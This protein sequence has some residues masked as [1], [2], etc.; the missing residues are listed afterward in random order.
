METPYKRRKLEAVNL[1]PSDTDGSE[2]EHSDSVHATRVSEP[3]FAY[4]TQPTQILPTTLPQSSHEEQASQIQVLASSPPSIKQSQ[5]PQETLANTIAPAGTS[6]RP[7]KAYLNRTSSSKDVDIINITDD[8][9]AQRHEMSSDDENESNSA[10]IKPTLFSSRGAHGLERLKQIASDARYMSGSPSRSPQSNSNVNLA[11]LPVNEGRRKPQSAEQAFRSLPTKSLHDVVKVN[12]GLS[13]A[14]IGDAQMQHKIKKMMEVAPSNSVAQC[15]DALIK[16]GNNYQDA[17]DHLFSL[18]GL[19]GLVD[20]TGSDND[21]ANRQESRPNLSSRQNWPAKHSI[22]P[23]VQKIHEKYSTQSKTRN[24]PQE[25]SR[26]AALPE[27]RRRLVQGRKDS[28]AAFDLQDKDEDQPILKSQSPQAELSDSGFSETSDGSEADLE[29][30]V[31]DFLNTCD[32][33]NIMDTAGASEATASK[34]ISRRPFSNLDNIRSLPKDN[35]GPKSRGQRTDRACES[36]VDKTLDMWRGYQA[37]DALIKRCEELARPLVEAMASWG[38]NAEHASPRERAV[39]LSIPHRGHPLRDSGVGSPSSRSESPN[40]DGARDHGALVQSRNIG[41]HDQPSVM[42]KEIKLKDFQVIGFNWLALL[43]DHK[44]SAILADD[45]GLGKTCQIIAFLAHLFEK[46]ISGPHLVIVPGSTLENWLREFA[47]FCPSLA[48]EPYYGSQSERP[49]IRERISTNRKDLNVVITTYTIAKMKDD[50]KFL[51]KLKPT[52]CI[53]DEGHVLKNSKSAGYGAYMGIQTDFRVLLS[54]TPV[55]NSLSELC[56]LLGFILP[57]VFQEYT[58]DLEAIFS[59]KARTT[60]DQRSHSALLSMQRVSRAKSIMTPFVLRR[61]KDQ[62]LQELPKKTKRV[63]YCIMSESQKRLYQLEKE[64]ARRL[65]TDGQTSGLSKASQN[66]M[67]ALRKAAIHPLLFRSLYTNN[68]L[69]E[70]AKIC[71]KEPEFAKSDV[72]LVY[73]DMTVMDDIELHL[74]CMRYPSTLS[75]YQLSDNEW[76]DSGK[77]KVLEGL[78]KT[79]KL[80]GEKV[81]VFSQFVQVLNILEL[82]LETLQIAFFRLDGQTKIE[83]RQ[84]MIDQYHSDTEITVFLLSTKAGGA[85]INLACANKVIIVDSSFNPQDDIQAENRAHRVGQTSEVEVVRLVS[86]STIEE[87]IHTLGLTKLL[88]DDR[89]A[90]APGENNN[91]LE[92]QGKTAL[93]DIVRS[94][95]V[96]EAERK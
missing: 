85:G 21:G 64:R 51:K 42:S 69:S 58:D 39:E 56:A 83:E 66:I 11:N 31:L 14:Q 40:L 19:A 7:P 33:T 76:M 29:Q 74:F 68:V 52:C 50:Q 93:E 20:L 34:I 57:S 88:L 48:V 8:E 65:F 84:T 72:D 73:E 23:P 67:M 5:T 36:A 17:L 46:G 44:L 95:I 81:L 2:D 54:G 49:M 30:A 89:V 24:L 87:D 41:L 16:K 92:D 63:E 25:Q 10:D 43:F 26:P 37:V 13:L 47:K 27:R 82:V 94:E 78:L 6:F 75:S 38:T 91:D 4:V 55:Q 32:L 71:L 96:K 70:M 60:D 35:I 86:Q 90:G 61:R 53:Y 79:Y 3:D 15:R 18:N 1:L 77:V 80:R 12:R 28:H 9:T 22:K 62:V 45:M 59:H